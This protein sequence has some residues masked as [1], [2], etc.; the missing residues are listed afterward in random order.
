MSA[1]RCA[2]DPGQ[3]PAQGWRGRRHGRLAAAA[4]AL[5]ALVVPTPGR[6]DAP[7]VRLGPLQLTPTSLVQL[8]GGGT[9]NQDRDNGQNSGVN[10]RRARLGGVASLADTVTAGFIWDFGGPTGNQSSLYQA[11]I[12][13]SGPL[14]LIARAGVFKAPFTMEYAQGAGDTLFLERA[15]IDTLV[16]G[17]VAGGGRVGGQ[18]GA[19]GERWFAAAFLTGGK[20]G[21][22]A[23]SEQRA[24]LAR[25]AGLAVQT[26]TV[27]VHLGASGAWLYQVARAGDGGRTLRL[28][29]Q[30]EIR[31]DRAP[32]PL[33]SG[34]IPAKGARIGGLEAGLTWNRTWLQAEGYV[35]TIDG[36][37]GFGRSPTTSGGYVQASYTLFGK[38]REW[39]SN[40][41]AWAKPTPDGNWGALEAGARFS[42]ADVSGLSGQGGRQAVWPAALNWYPRTPLRFTLE[43]GHARVQGGAA[44]RSFDF[45]AGRAQIAF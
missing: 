2:S 32:A 14:P 18:L 35:I 9:F 30:P 21:Q 28:A 40:V 7:S 29:D 43:Y 34:A 1:F 11:D 20:T 22:G 15:T 36:G 4:L 27:S 12:A 3:H 38:P 31:L 39:S 25:V 8:D 33:T 16:T 10:F 44:P 26:G 5:A 19:K 17:L 37:R 23:R 45:V 42:Y 6:A 24:V 41:A 13:Y